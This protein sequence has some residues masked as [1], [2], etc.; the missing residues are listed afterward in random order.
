MIENI[1]KGNR[2]FWPDTSCDLESLVVM[3]QDAEIVPAS[4]QENHGI[5]MFRCRKTGIRTAFFKM[6]LEQYDPK[7]FPRRGTVLV[8]FGESSPP[9]DMS[10]RSFGETPRAF[11]GLKKKPWVMIG[12]FLFS[13]LFWIIISVLLITIF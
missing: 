2:F 9:D 10:S 11:R 5:A 12:A 8:E 1:A 3:N 7:E 13:C 4:V 6:V